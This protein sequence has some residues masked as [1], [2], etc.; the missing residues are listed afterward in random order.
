MHAAERRARNARPAARRWNAHG[1]GV[2]SGLQLADVQGRPAEVPEPA[3]RRGGRQLMG[4]LFRYGAVL[5]G[6]AALAVGAVS[7][8]RSASGETAP[9]AT[10]AAGVGYAPVKK[11]SL[12]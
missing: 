10:G 2:R 9:P 1:A 11:G 8:S 7:W 4:R 3:P 6:V 5:V 12:N